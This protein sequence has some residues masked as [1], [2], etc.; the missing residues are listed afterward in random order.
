MRAPATVERIE[1]REH[2]QAVLDTRRIAD[3]EAREVALEVGAQRA[4]QLAERGRVDDQAPDVGGHGIAVLR[5]LVGVVDARPRRGAA[6]GDQQED[7]HASHAA[8]IRR[9]CGPARHAV[10]AVTAG[11]APRG[12]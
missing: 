5:Q 12:E 2:E 4:R 1:Q 3:V 7:D 9:A 11:A 10:T 6:R 8:S